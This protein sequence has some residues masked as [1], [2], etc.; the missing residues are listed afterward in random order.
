MV[1]ALKADIQVN[2]Q[3]RDPRNKLMHIQLIFSKGA[4]HTQWRIISSING[5]GQTG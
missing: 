2:R 3:K 1:L 4:R 5:T